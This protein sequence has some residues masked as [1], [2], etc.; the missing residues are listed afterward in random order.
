[1]NNDLLQTEK[2]LSELKGKKLKK[3]VQ[4]MVAPTFTNLWHS[5]KKLKGSK[6]EV[7]AQNMHF[8]ENGA[9]TGEISANMIKGVGVNIV[10]KE[11]GLV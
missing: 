7:A 10:R 8:A 4:V 1:M 11:P 9:F 2:L 6:I 5:V 3:G